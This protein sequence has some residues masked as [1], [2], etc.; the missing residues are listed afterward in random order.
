LPTSGITSNCS[1]PATADTPAT[2]GSR[3]QQ[4]G[5]NSKEANNSSAEANNN[6][7]EANN[8][9]NRMSIENTSS[10]RETST[11]VGKAAT[12]ET[13][14]IAGISWTN[15]NICKNTSTTGPTAPQETTGTA[16]DTINKR[17]ATTGGNITG[18]RF[19]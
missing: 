14:A 9:R 10:R 17:E 5:N 4:G 1:T 13:L 8:S 6:S 2:A 16:G 3:Q 11:A 7:A 18:R 19:F 12:A 15:K